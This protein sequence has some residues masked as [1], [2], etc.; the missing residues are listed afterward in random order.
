MS[1]VRMEEKD[2][3]EEEEYCSKSDTFVIISFSLYNSSNDSSHPR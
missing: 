2:F 3:E 1:Y